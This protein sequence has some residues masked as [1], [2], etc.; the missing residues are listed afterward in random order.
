[1]GLT[2]RRVILSW[3]LRIGRLASSVV[4][5]V[6]HGDSKWRRYDTDWDDHGSQLVGLPKNRNEK[7]PRPLII[8][9]QS[10]KIVLMLQIVLVLVGL[11]GSGK[12]RFMMCNSAFLPHIGI[13]HLCT[14]T[15][16]TSACIVP[17][18]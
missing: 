10:G 17:S 8:R 15:R 12:V 3:A 18:T 13:V 11:I 7:L 2:Q 6:G 1:M 4:V 16:A 5:L 14:D 9:E